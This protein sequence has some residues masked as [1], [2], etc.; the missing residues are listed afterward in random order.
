MK[1][2]EWKNDNQVSLRNCRFSASSIL[3][4][5]NLLSLEKIYLVLSEKLCCFL[6]KFTGEF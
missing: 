1:Y 5:L 4:I 3:A 2:R 6:G